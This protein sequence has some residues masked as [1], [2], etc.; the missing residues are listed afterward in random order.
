MIAAVENVLPESKLTLFHKLIQVL[1]GTFPFGTLYVDM[2]S[3]RT[4]EVADAAKKESDGLMEL[5]E[6]I[7]SAL[8]AGTPEASRFLESLVS[9]EPFSRHA[10]KAKEII[11]ALTD[12][13]H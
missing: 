4:P 11:Q 5:A 7:V 2:A 3:E 13:R 1:E 12:E 6:R 10:E 8:G 9:V